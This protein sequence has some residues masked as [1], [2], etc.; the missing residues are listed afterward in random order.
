[1]FN[2]WF[3]IVN[4]CLYNEDYLHDTLWSECGRRLGG[5]WCLDYSFK[6][7]FGL[8]NEYWRDNC[9]DK[10]KTNKDLYDLFEDLG[11]AYKKEDSEYIHYKGKCIMKKLE[12]IKK[13]KH[14]F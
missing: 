8:T 3:K 10:L 5:Q 12:E 2:A 6:L 7:I 11:I 4:D 9:N 13:N 14:V 1:M